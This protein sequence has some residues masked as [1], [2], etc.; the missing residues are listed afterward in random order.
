MKPHA[1]SRESALIALLLL[2]WCLPAFAAAK[3]NIVIIYA[4]DMGWGDLGCYG[5]PSIRTPNLDRMA[6]EGM[7][8]T[9]FYSA[10]EVCTP[11]RASLL[12]GRYP[13]RS[14]MCHDQ[15]RVLHNQARGGLPRDE[16]TLA[17]LLKPQSYATAMVGKW[18]L[19]HLPQHLP[20]QHGFDSYFGMPYSNDMLP[21]TNAPPGR[22]RFFTENNDFWRTPLIRG[23]NIVEE[24]PD[25]RQ[26]TRR[27]TEE[28]QKIIREK[29]GG[30][31]FL[32]L[33]H[34]FPHV[35]LFASERFRG[36]SP[37][38]RYG[39]VI[40][41]LD[42]SVGEVLNTLRAEGVASNTLVVFSSDNGPWLIFNQ[43]GGSA[44]PFR[45][46]K[47]STWEGGM[48]VPGLA[49]WPGRVK[50]GAVQH[51]LATTMDVF[52]TCAKLAGAEVPTDRVIDGKD[53]SPL[54]FDTG[55][56]ERD[57]FLYY[58]GATL[59]AARLG[60]WKAHFITRSGYGPDQPVTNT[61]PLL[62]HLGDDP[63]EKF[64]VASNQP[65]VLARI[66]EAVQRHRA[67][68][69]PA[70]SQMEPVPARR[71]T[72]A[73]AR[74]E[75]GSRA[76]T[77]QRIWAFTP[78]PQLPNVLILGDSISIGY[79][80]DV[81]E[82]LKGKANVFRPLTADGKN[83]ENCSGTTHG[84]KSIDRWLGDRK[85][86][87]IHFNFGLHDLKHVAKAGADAAT[88]QASD[89]RQAD[90]EQYR[91]NLEAII[92]KLKAT[93][94]RLIF[95]TTTPVAPG[96]TNPL[97]EPDAPPRYNAAALEVMKAHG[98]RV[99]DLFAFCAPQLGKLQRPRNVHFTTAG[100]KALAQ[101]VAGVIQEELQAG[102]AK[103]P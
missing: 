67:N 22:D 34:S 92:P 65:A 89:P 97:R 83:A 69:R 12:T 78:D 73:N 33:A 94:A 24:H 52:T 2:A 6:A 77:E 61:P 47:G 35:P 9:D 64:N 90:E 18:H 17:E 8:F 26:L 11:S 59:Y 3:P 41:E 62:F 79:T 100:S 21:A 87:V 63:G 5:H 99:N 20:P 74:A 39:D 88:S 44:G 75:Q 71:A 50:A 68:L 16:I 101:Q 103:K 60:P 46:G 15:R 54:L 27:Y 72:N 23:T 38:G 1:T 95:A 84:V 57:A 45:E 14:G 98:I 40:E 25:Q 82:M 36:K 55:T 13:I 42:W 43:H 70:P 37:A 53:I 7:R 32:Y 102:A 56:V 10:A 49:W 28:A 58:R 19:G 31:F 30:P 96:T 86:D 76:E 51:E 66:E 29:K 81:R 91:K 93:S 80:L 85:W 48:R 4:D